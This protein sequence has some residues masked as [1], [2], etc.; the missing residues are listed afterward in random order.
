MSSS[1]TQEVQR[2]MWE[3]TDETPSHG[4]SDDESNGVQLD[5]DIC[6]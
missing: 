6:E 5:G 3:L 1:V 4:E 2:S